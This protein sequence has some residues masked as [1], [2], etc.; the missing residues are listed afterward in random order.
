MLWFVHIQIYHMRSIQSVQSVDT[1]QILVKNIGKKFNGFSNTC[2][3]LLMFVCILR[4][5][6]MESLGMSILNFLVTLIK[7]GLLQGTC[8]LLVVVLSVG[9][10]LTNY[11]CLLLKLSTW[12]L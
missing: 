1:W 11:N 6:D 3:A 2:V 4:E 7:E 9:K 10:L 8:L 12:L 5:L